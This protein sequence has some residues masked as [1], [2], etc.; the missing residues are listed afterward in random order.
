MKVTSKHI[1]II[2][3]IAVITY[4][5]YKSYYSEENVYKRALKYI[6]DNTNWNIDGVKTWDKNFVIALYNGLKD[7]KKSIEYLGKKYS[8]ETAKVI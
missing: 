1:I 5:A 7:D 4:F 6:G 2:I 3:F 8:T